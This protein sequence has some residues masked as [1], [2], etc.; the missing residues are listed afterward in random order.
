MVKFVSILFV[1]FICVGCRFRLASR[2]TCVPAGPAV[3]AARAAGAAA[4]A[5]RQQRRRH[6]LP[7]Q[8]SPNPVQAP[9]QASTQTHLGLLASLHGGRSPLLQLR[10][11]TGC[12]AACTAGGSVREGPASWPTLTATQRANGHGGVHREK[13]R[14]G[15]TQQCGKKQK[16][17]KPQL[18]SR[19]AFFAF[20]SSLTRACTFCLQVAKKGRQASNAGGWVYGAWQGAPDAPTQAAPNQLTGAPSAP[21]GRRHPPGTPA[22]PR[23]AQTGHGQ[24]TR[25]GVGGWGGQTTGNAGGGGRWAGRQGTRANGQAGSFVPSVPG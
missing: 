21:C 7:V 16:Q 15:A 11:R 24:G 19:N 4:G 20:S 25:P 9:Q 23:S 6:P 12:A 13:E 18:A 17:F 2:L 1:Y 22:P 10:L 8:P 3:P 5:N 14:Q